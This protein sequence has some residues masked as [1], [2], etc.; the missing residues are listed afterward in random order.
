VT[1]CRQTFNQFV[2]IREDRLAASRGLW[3]VRRSRCAL[4]LGGTLTL[5][6]LM[7]NRRELMTYEIK[8]A[9]AIVGLVATILGFAAFSAKA[10]IVVDDVTNPGTVGSATG[11]FNYGSYDASS[12]DK[13]VVLVG[14]GRDRGSSMAINGVT[15]GGAALTEAVKVSST[16]I[17]PVGVA[18]G[19]YYLDDPGVA[20]DIVVNASA[21][22]WGPR[23]SVTILALSGTASGHGAVGSSSNSHFV[24]L[25]TTTFDSLVLA[26]SKGVYDQFAETPQAPLTDRGGAR[27][28]SG[29][30]FVASPT[31][32][33][34]TFANFSGDGAT[35]AAAFEAANIPE[36]NTLVLAVLGLLGFINRGRGRRR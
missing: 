11:V 13:L 22:A 25:A 26:V 8:R 28:G 4:D 7:L 29:S 16:T 15:Y 14:L 5:R 27:H 3:P 31:T 6:P 2:R 19:I 35:V 17:S 21:K 32:V 18:A 33:A 23:S 24:S 1:Y 30:Q 10:A 12:A 36:P 34:P 20:G 9:P